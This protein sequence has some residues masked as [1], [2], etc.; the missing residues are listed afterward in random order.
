MK[1]RAERAAT[2]R[3]P[4][5]VRRLVVLA[6]AWS[7]AVLVVAGLALSI[8]FSHVETARFD[9]SLTDTVDGLLAG[10]SVEAGVVMPLALYRRR[11]PARLFGRLLGRSPPRSPAPY[12]PWRA[13]ARS[14]ITH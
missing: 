9:D 12:I 3:R 7:L 1:A 5:L 2:R 4:S 8:F 14:G 10:A 6:A 11:S 13:R